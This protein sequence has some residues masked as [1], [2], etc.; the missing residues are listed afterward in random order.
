MEAWIAKLEPE[1]KSSGSRNTLCFS[2]AEED[3]IAYQL[4][5]IRQNQIPCLLSCEVLKVDSQIRLQYDVTSLLPLHKVL[6]RRVIN[7][8][9]FMEIAGQITGLFQVLDDYLMDIGG[10]LLDSRF[11]YCAPD[12][13][14]LYFIHIPDRNMP[15]G[16]HEALKKLLL[17]LVVQEIKF[18]DEATDNY[19]QRLIERLKDPDFSLDTLKAYLDDNK[20]NTVAKPHTARE[21]S[22]NTVF[23]PQVPLPGSIP[24]RTPEAR[25]DLPRQPQSPAAQARPPVLNEPKKAIKPVVQTTEKQIK[26]Y[27]LKSYIILG[28]AIVGLLAL[29]LVL[30]LNGSLSPDNPDMVTTLVGMLLIGGALIYLVCSKVFTPDKKVVKV[31]AQ[32]VL[33]PV[34]PAPSHNTILNRTENSKGSYVNT[35]I[36]PVLPA[37]VAVSQAQSAFSQAAPTQT[38]PRDKTVLLSEKA[39]KV[40]ALKRLGANPETIPISKWPFMI[41]RL[42]DQ[43]DYCIN[44]PAIGKLHAELIKKEDVYYITDMN[45]KNGSFVNGTRVEAGKELQIKDGDRILLANEEFMFC[46]SH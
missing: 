25:I 3:L 26:V 21:A 38:K 13:N 7:R 19:V 16:H 12:E 20:L 28:S 40:P 8:L 6:E 5:M 34:L 44:N 46:D 10:V 43:V 31:V 23:T 14:K 1:Y 45:T 29:L 24:Q 39:L 33:A 15:Q 27:P 30:F 41:G 36:R 22:L 17:N 37:P 32:K 42:S 2:F 35:N 18:A 4:E 9:D 11:I